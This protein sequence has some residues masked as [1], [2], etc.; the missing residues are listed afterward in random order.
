MT[1]K[2]PAR[3]AE[4]IDETALSY[5]EIKMLAT[6]NPYIK[7]KMDL[8]IQ[9]QKLELLKSS[10]NSVKYELEDKIIKYYPQKILETE[11]VI[12]GLKADIKIANSNKSDKFTGLVL[13]GQMY[14]D[15]KEA[16]TQLLEVTK[17]LNHLSQLKLVNIEVL[18]CFVFMIFGKGNLI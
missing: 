4:D 2:S 7:E 6:G 3:I 1:S 17:K 18:M 13:N 16:G 15:K 14:S 11:T 8:D 5:A 9:V 10:F 12:E